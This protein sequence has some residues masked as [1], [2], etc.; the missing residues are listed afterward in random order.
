[1]YLKSIS[2][3]QFRNYHTQAFAFEPCGSLI[4][5]PN[6]SGKTNLLE[7]IAYCGIGK[8]IRLHHDEQLLSFNATT[9]SIA[10]E[11]EQDLGLD[12]TVS[13][14][15][16]NKKKLLKLD[17]VPVRHLSD[18]FNSIKIIYCAPEDLQLVNGSPRIRRQY[19]DLAISQLYPEYISILRNYLHIV[20]QRNSLLKTQYS[21]SE[22]RSWDLKFVEGSMEVVGY[23]EK[24]LK[25]LNEY[26]Q[27]D[28]LHFSSKI[29]NTG[30]RY[31]A[32]NKTMIEHS[33]NVDG[34]LALL[35]SLESREKIYQRSLVGA[36]IDDYEFVLDETNLR[37]YGS[38]GQKRIVVILLKLIQATLVEQVTGIKPIL[39][40]DDIFAEL[41]IE[42]STNIHR[43]IDKRYQVIIASPN[44]NISE[45]WD[46][47]PSQ[48]LENTI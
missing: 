31:L 48:Y 20:E 28:Y 40:F 3:G 7:A 47:I 17:N 8:S 25:L 1:M 37:I 39:L 32:T 15:Y 24:Y 42:N 10:A 43:F 19:F 30:I 41:D 12:L 6:G 13:F 4:I 14:T 23:R 35:Q 29:Y 5:G 44:T 33:A 45:I 46:S 22:K 34:Y 2:L 16:H 27:K 38:Q 36:H 21:V 11:F 26:F 9:F 18:L